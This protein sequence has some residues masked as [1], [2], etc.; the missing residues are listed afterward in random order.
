MGLIFR[1][2]ALVVFTRKSDSNLIVKT[3][4]ELESDL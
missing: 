2:F 3:V 1:L 4:A